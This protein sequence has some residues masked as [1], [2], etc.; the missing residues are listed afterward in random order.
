MVLVF[1]ILL[2]GPAYEEEKLQR[3]GNTQR[4]ETAILKK[5]LSK[6]KLECG[7]SVKEY[8]LAVQCPLTA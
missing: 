6:G 3:E 1:L 2:L 8:H 5:T 4:E 7:G